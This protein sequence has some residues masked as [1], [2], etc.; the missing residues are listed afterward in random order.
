MVQLSL[1]NYL[2]QIAVPLEIY[3]DTECN[4]EKILLIIETKALDT[5]KNIKIILLVV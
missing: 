2:K 1:K 3:A 4:S 5:L